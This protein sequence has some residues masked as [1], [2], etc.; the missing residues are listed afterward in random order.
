[1]KE[2]TVPVNLGFLVDVMWHP[3]WRRV[4][5]ELQILEMPIAIAWIVIFASTST[6]VSCNKYPRNII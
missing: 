3:L 5:I 4:N 6:E 2:T 1:L